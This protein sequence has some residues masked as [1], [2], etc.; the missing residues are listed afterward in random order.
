MFGMVRCGA[1]AIL[2]KLYVSR[3]PGG[4]ERKSTY[5]RPSTAVNFTQFQ[6]YRA[7]LRKKDQLP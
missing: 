3:L 5:S 2:G 6:V 7:Y 1:R 4:Y